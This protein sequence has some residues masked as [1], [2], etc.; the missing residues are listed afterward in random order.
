[1]QISRLSLLVGLLVLFLLPASPFLL[2]LLLFS[3]FSVRSILITCHVP[4]ILA[5]YLLP[6]ICFVFI[7]LVLKLPQLTTFFSI[8][9]YKNM[10]GT[11]YVNMHA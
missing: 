2:L 8:C 1:M 3:P 10:Q 11:V 9:A 7:F 5:A 4:F 6:S